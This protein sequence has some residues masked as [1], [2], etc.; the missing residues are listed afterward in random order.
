MAPVAEATTSVEARSTRSGLGLRITV[1]GLTGLAW[2]AGLRGFMVEVAESAAAGSSSVDWA[3]TFGWI[4]LPGV[5]TGVLLGWADHIRR[6][7]GRRGWRWLALSPLALGAVVLLRPWD[8]PLLLQDP[9]GGGAVGVALYGLIGGH[10]LSSRGPLWG[11][12]VSRLF[13]LS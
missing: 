12:L 9:I 1:G 10:A 3:G 8:L 4:L 2:A 5:I 13:L 7:G 11:R 6:T